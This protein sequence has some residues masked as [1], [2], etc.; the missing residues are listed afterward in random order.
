MQ[1]SGDAEPNFM[2]KRWF[3][4]RRKDKS[5]IRIISMLNQQYLS[6]DYWKRNVN[7]VIKSFFLGVVRRTKRANWW[8]RFIKTR[9][10]FLELVVKTSVT[11]KSKELLGALARS[12]SWADV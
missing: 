1:F 4:K 7:G 2:V 10:K 12:R 9:I 6:K 3:A 5:S 11:F 8:G